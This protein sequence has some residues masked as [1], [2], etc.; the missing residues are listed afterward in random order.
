M[1]KKKLFGKIELNK[2]GNTWP[3]KIFILC[4]ITLPLIIFCIFTVY[5]N[6]GGLIQ[7]FMWV[8]D[9]T[10]KEVT[11]FGFKNF[12][13]FFNDFKLMKMHKILPTSFSYLFIVMFISLPISIICSFFLYKKIPFSKFIVV[14]LFMPNIL[15]APLLASYYRELLLQSDQATG[16]IAQLLDFLLTPIGQEPSVSWMTQRTN[17]V[18]YIYTI[19]FGFGYNAILI[20]GAMTRIPE[21]IVESAE[22][23]GANLLVEFF[24][25]TIP[26]IWP[27][28]SMVIVLT[29][30]VPFSIYSQPMMIANETN[31]NRYGALTWSLFVMNTIKSGTKANIYFASALSVMASCISLPTT[32][33]IQKALQKVYPVVEV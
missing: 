1:E 31:Q 6:F 8:D 27:T 10:G 14:L 17:Q 22:L 4:L 28:L 26:I 13:N 9:S 32:L 7:A 33:L 20:W 19:Y 18:L 11:N 29:W 25:I 2:Y 16:V 5:G 15:P 12:A 23:D 3:T 24:N 21:E 30:M